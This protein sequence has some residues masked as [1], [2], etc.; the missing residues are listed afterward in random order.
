M[1]L[2]NG[3]R[4][5]IAS[6]EMTLTFRAWTRPQVAAGSAYGFDDGRQLFVESISQVPAR[7]ID[8]AQAM[9]AGEPS[10]AAMRAML[11][12]VSRRTISDEDLIY[13]IAFRLEPVTSTKAPLEPGTIVDKLARMDARSSNGPWTREYLRMIAD[14]P[15]L[16]AKHHAARLGRETL[17]LKAD[18]R[19]LKALGLTVSYEVGYGLTPLGEQVLRVLDAGATA[20]D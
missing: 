5:K 17:D 1:L 16:G 18:V 11:N 10:A 6:G 15:R 7:T 2:T 13:R 8:D 20:T 12:K 19:K 9:H 14:N 3:Q 4:A